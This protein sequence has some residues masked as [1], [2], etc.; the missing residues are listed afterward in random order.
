MKKI[1]KR[2]YSYKTKY[3]Q[4]FIQSEIEDILT[5]YPD[6]NMGKFNEALNGITALLIDEHIITYHC[7]IEKALICGVENRDLRASEWD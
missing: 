2:V 3:E 7:D 1:T 4:G 5:H 6:I